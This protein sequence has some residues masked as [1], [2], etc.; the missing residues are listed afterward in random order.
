MNNGRRR[1]IALG[2][3]VFAAPLS[4]L[5]Q[6]PSA[7]PAR[8]GLLGPGS[9]SSN[10]IWTA[11]LLANLRDLGYVEGKNLIVESRWSDGKNDRLPSLAAELVHRNV[12]VIATYQTPAS[13]AAKQA[14]KTI[15]IVMVAAADPVATGLIH[16]LARPGGNV[17]GLSGATS[18]LAAKN[19]ELIR[20]ILPST[21]RVA[22]LL[23][24]DDTYT[25]SFLQQIQRAASATG[26]ELQTIM[27]HGGDSLDAAFAEIART[28]ASAVI[29][30]PSLPY[31][32]VVEM[33]LRH[34]L[35]STSAGQGFAELGGLFVY[36]GSMADRD[37][38]AAIYV[39]KILKGAAPADLPVR[40]PT[41][42]ELVINLKTAKQIGVTIPPSVLA[43]ADRVI[44]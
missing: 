43:R 13:L 5:A 4:A 31:E 36:N 7:K 20:E 27:I 2:A 25:E 37:R 21:K 40:Q 18:E 29:V 42:F 22:V 28:R 15:P 30:Q 41:K 26:V 19:L 16:S 8:I 1:A 24:A 44:E 17:T 12:D 23:N 3:C 34:R 35:V 14:T 38:Q 6:A 11:T 9:A 33:A 32:P 39:D 10:K